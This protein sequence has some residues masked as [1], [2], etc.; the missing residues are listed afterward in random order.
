M[1][2]TIALLKTAENTPVLCEMKSGETYG[3]T[4]RKIDGYMNCLLEDVIRTSADGSSFWNM[5]Q[6][7]VRGSELKYFR[8]QDE[9]LLDKVPENQ[10]KIEMDAMSYAL[11]R[12]NRDPTKIPDVQA[13]KRKRV[14]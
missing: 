13:R 2:R 3:G 14:P 9:D 11:G 6:L 5:S 10:E 4:L 1:V 8:L 7:I 12:P